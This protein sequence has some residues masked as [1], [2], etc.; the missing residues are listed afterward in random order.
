M[1]RTAT[2]DF[3][4]DDWLLRAVHPTWINPN[5]SIA[6]GAFQNNSRPV[7]TDRMSVAAEQLATPKQVLAKFPR[8]S[9]K[10]CVVR[11]TVA[12]CWSLNQSVEHTP[13][14][15]FE[16]HSDVVG[17]KDEITQ[18]EFAEKCERLDL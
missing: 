2:I 7:K 6:P 12:T 3:Q 16:A 5:G 4:A 15:S 10:G 18:M 8:W 1:S 9:D 11:V 17:E 14:E 13:A